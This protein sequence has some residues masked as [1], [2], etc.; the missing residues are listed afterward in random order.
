MTLELYAARMVGSGQRDDGSHP[1][2]S[3]AVFVT[4]GE[5][6]RTATEGAA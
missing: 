5:T 1:W 2:L 3:G 6:G 4:L